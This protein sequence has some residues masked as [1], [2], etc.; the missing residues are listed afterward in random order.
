M[1]SLFL[2][3]LR[4]MICMLRSTNLSSASLA[5]SYSLYLSSKCR[6]IKNPV[7]LSQVGRPYVS[8][9]YPV[10]SEVITVSQN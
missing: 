3:Y 2:V 9:T 6:V 4:R 8:C 10:Y 1:Q 5:A 7:I